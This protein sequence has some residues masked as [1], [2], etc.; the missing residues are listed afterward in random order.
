[1]FKCVYCR[2]IPHI[3]VNCYCREIKVPDFVKSPE[4]MKTGEFKIIMSKTNVG[5]SLIAE[6]NK[7]A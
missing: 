4:G 1:M 7:D 2:D 6:N 3:Q 5:K